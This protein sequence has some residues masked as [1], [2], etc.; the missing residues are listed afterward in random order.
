MIKA[1]LIDDE[2][3]L[4]KNL[5]GLLKKY[6]PQV[7]VTGSANSLSA[8]KELIEAALPDL[9]FLDI[10][11]PYG[12]GF[13][14]LKSFESPTFEVIFVTAFDHYAVKAFKQSA[15]GYILKPIDIDELKA[16]THKAESIIKS[17][18]GNKSIEHLL[19]AFNNKQSSPTKIGLPTL[20]G[21]MFV[22]LDTIVFCKSSGSYT[23]FHFKDGSTHLISKQ[24][25][26]CEKILPSNM[27]FR[28]HN[29][30]IINLNL[31]S[32]YVKGRGGYVILE[33]GIS[34]NV[35]LR[36]KEEFL[37]NVARL[38]SLF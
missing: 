36:R 37:Q 24:I 18:Q 3:L 1:V 11:M 23:E 7:E 15:I 10:E 35:S 30:N 27:F 12:S 33:N 31:V 8:G 16:A 17:H 21:L 9:V 19:N 5:E 4:V 2:P 13:D 32:K 20:E 26:D 6:C 28:I 29:E 22:K 34:F 14:L 38:N 25:S